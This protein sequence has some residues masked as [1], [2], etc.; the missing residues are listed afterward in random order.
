MKK[1]RLEAAPLLPGPPANPEMEKWAKA[2]LADKQ[3]V[4]EQIRQVRYTH[5]HTLYYLYCSCDNIHPGQPKLVGDFHP[6]ISRS[7][8]RF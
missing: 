6:V 8:K 7:E 3:P 5:T 2:S 4:I 1:E